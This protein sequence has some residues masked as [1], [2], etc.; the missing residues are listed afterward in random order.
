MQKLF[1]N[2]L[3]E[4]NREREELSNDLY[5][6]E[7]E[8]DN[9]KKEME[10]RLDEVKAEMEYKMQQLVKENAEAV[11]SRNQEID[12]NLKIMEDIDVKNDR[13]QQLEKEV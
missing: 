1:D 13:I 7:K 3:N 10:Q 11:A 2:K 8:V 4:L 12:K 5:D 9:V 6:K